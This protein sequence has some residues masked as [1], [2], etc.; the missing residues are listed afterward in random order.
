VDDSTSGIAELLAVH[1]S[2]LHHRTQP[3][4]HAATPSAHQLHTPPIRQHHS[5]PRANRRP[6]GVFHFCPSRSIGLGSFSHPHVFHNHGELLTG[7]GKTKGTVGL[8]VVP[9]SHLSSLCN[10]APG[11]RVPLDGRVPYISAPTRHFP[12]QFEVQTHSTPSSSS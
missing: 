10:Y 9:S 11:R 6:V 5:R 4:A 1:H 7:S 8:S 2:S 3:L 12:L